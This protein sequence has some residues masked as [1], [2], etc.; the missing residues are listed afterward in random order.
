MFRSLLRNTPRYGDGRKRPD[1][2]G[3]RRYRHD[4]DYGVDDPTPGVR[5][6]EIYD[7]EA[8]RGQKR[9]QDRDQENNPPDP[10]Q[11][12]DQGPLGIYLGGFRTLCKDSDAANSTPPRGP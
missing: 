6:T 8:P 7:I 3:N 4:I 10:L 12:A 1:P 9:H 5:L 11:S 2:V